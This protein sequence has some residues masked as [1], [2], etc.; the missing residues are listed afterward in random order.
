MQSL[1]NITQIILYCTTISS[2]VIYISF[3]HLYTL[4]S[5]DRRLQVY[6]T[7][8]IVSSNTESGEQG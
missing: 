4:S 3:I 1:V 7:Y 5:R 6:R 2:I 8:I